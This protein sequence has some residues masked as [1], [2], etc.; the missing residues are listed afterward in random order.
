M[1][2]MLRSGESRPLL[3]LLPRELHCITHNTCSIASKTARECAGLALSTSHVHN[4]SYTTA[5]TARVELHNRDERHAAI[6][7]VIRP[8]PLLLP[9]LQ[10][11]SYTA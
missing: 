9:R 8:L 11:V 1:S 4:R 10:K 3:L 6:R 7:R 5:S 2:N